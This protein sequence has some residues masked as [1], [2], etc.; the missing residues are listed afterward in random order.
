M[1]TLKRVLGMACA[2]AMLLGMSSVFA[3]EVGGAYAI[4]VDNAKERPAPVAG[5]TM[6]ASQ[7]GSIIV[8]DA[9]LD[10]SIMTADVAANLK[11]KIGLAARDLPNGDGITSA[12]A[13][14]PVE[15]DFTGHTGA[16]SG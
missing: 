11:A 5:P 2:A 1:K 7:P 4:K 6:L 8:L 10:L 16:R 14:D 12:A 15:P 9:K 3:L 13:V